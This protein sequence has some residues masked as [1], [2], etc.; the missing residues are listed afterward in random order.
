MYHSIA[1]KFMLKRERSAYATTFFQIIFCYRGVTGNIS[2]QRQPLDYPPIKTLLDGHFVF[3]L[4]KIYITKHLQKQ[5]IVK[6]EKKIAS[7]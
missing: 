2:D 7:Y 5:S 3:S 6:M 1:L 4:A